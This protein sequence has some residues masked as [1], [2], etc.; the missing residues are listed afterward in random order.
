MKKIAYLSIAAMLGAASLVSCSDFLD[1]NNKSLGADVDSYFSTPEG[2]TAARAQAFAALKNLGVNYDLYCAGTDLYIPVRGKDPGEYQRYSL[3]ADD[4]TLNTFYSNCFTLIKYSE[5][6]VKYAGNDVQKAAEGKFLHAYAY[7]LL[8]QQFG[9]VPYIDQYIS[10]SN[11]DYPKLSVDEIYTK[12]EAELE[13]IYNNG[14][15]PETAHDGS[16]SKQAVASLLAKFYLAHGWDV[17][18]QLSDAS[19]GTYTVNS[20]DNFAKAADWA[21]KGI[22]GQKLTQTFEQKWSP[23]NDGNAEQIFS[24]QYSRN[25]YPGN[26]DE[27]GHALQNLFANYYDDPTKTGMKKGNS[28]GCPTEKGLYLWS[29]GDD[30]YAGTFMTTFYNWDGKTG[31]EWNQTGYYAYYNNPKASS[32][33]I[34]YQYFPGYMTVDEVK[35][36]IAA[37]PERYKTA[38]YTVKSCNV[39]LL[40]SPATQFVINSNGVVTDTKTLS[41]TDLNLAVGAGSTVKKF[42]DPN[43]QCLNSDKIDYRP[44]VV[45]DLGDIYLTAAEAYLM[46]GDEDKALSYVN[47]VRDRSHATHLSSFGAYEPE[48]SVPS[49]FGTVTALDVI[50]D[51]RAREL[52]GQQ[53]RWMDLRRTRQL[54]RYNVAYN[55]YIGSASDMT[56]PDG[57]IKWLRPLPSGAINGNNSLTAADQNPGY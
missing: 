41:F 25:A 52:Y 15:L 3:S 13:D 39:Y 20:R 56:G 35:A 34:A 7:Y 36:E 54:V 26:I 51:E 21:V 19:R 55:L 38:G 9:G 46:A 48:Y 27:G 53:L 45:L 8:T 44:I 33:P 28:N 18:T 37:H 17:D 12:V 57:N 2:L 6:Y 42:D 4:P 1:T 30:R 50:L 5:F 29:R 40:G 49:T 24:I 14:N 43:S 10:D 22:N 31:D 11:R 47:D 16:V 32:L 23:S